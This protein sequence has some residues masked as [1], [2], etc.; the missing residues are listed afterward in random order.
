MTHD[1]RDRDLPWK[2]FVAAVQGSSAPVQLRLRNF[3]DV[4]TQL[5]CEVDHLGRHV[6]RVNLG[7]RFW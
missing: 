1:P 3:R 7:F 6:S 5:L 4:P 2:I